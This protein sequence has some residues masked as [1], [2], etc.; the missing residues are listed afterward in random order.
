MKPKAGALALAAAAGMLSGCGGGRLVQ[1]EPGK[2]LESQAIPANQARFLFYTVGQGRT[3]KV[4]VTVKR[5]SPI[6]AYLLTHEEYEKMQRGES[7][8]SLDSAEALTS[9]IL[10]GQVAED[11]FVVLLSN[12]FNDTPVLVDVIL[13]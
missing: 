4:E 10:S 1:V 5:G 12:N 9:R 13:E 7:W 3:V 8:N 2:Y 11:R 6:N